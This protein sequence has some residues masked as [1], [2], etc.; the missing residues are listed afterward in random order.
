MPYASLLI[1]FLHGFVAFINEFNFLF[2]HREF[3]IL[4]EVW[5]CLEG[6]IALSQAEPPVPVLDPSRR[7]TQQIV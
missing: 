2:Y 1:L 3:D 5:L 4:V 7:L 6:L